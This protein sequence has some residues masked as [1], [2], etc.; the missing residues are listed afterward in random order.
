MIHRM[1]PPDDPTRTPIPT[2]LEPMYATAANN[3]PADD[4]HYAY[5]MK[6]DGMRA[7]VTVNGGRVRLTTRLG[8]DATARF[9]ELRA[10][11][12]ALGAVDAV[13]DGEIVAL[14][15]VGRPSFEQLQPRIHVGSA[16]VA[17]RL[18]SERPVVLM[19]FDV[20]WLDGHSVLELP[21]AERRRL[22]ERLA[23]AGPAWQTPPTTIGPGGQAVLDTATSL[24]LEGVMAKR[25]DSTYQ[26]G[27]RSD[28]WR[29]V[30]TVQNQE[31][32]VGGWLPG[33]G[34]LEGRLGSLLV[35]YH[36]DTGA[37]QYAG[38]VGSGLDEQKRATLEALLAPL[39]RDA[40][41]FVKVPKLAHP[42]WVEP[43]VVVDVAFHE[44]T[45]A[46]GLRAPRYRGLRVDKPA[47][48]VV[49]EAT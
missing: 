33:S 30:K 38:R 9:P 46:G 17:R 45:T 19:L 44:W 2:G 1:S 48:E 6:W 16:S 36:D 5:E 4:E 29:K 47:A 23:L 41:P 18:A 25:L 14:D 7:I 37:L 3:L 13:L 11:G 8:N 32:V 22:L 20:L 27:R 35:G 28:A 34:R 39:R 42:V 31:L 43:D 10:L 49:R 24:G 12:E 21:Y 26:P 15:E 40:C